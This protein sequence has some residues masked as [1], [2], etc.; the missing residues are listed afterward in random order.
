MSLPPPPVQRSLFDVENLLG[1][2]FEPADRLRLFRGRVY[3]RLLAARA[4]LESCYCLDNGRRAEEPV[5]R[6]S[7]VLAHRNYDQPPEVGSV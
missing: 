3:R 4:E 1:R 6:N 7:L 5:V 2:Q